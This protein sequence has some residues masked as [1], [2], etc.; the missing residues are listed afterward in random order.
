MPSASLPTLR[1][2]DFFLILHQKTGLLTADFRE[3]PMVLDWRLV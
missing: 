2:G 1:L 3:F